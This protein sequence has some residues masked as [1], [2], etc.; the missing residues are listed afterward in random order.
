MA[1]MYML[2]DFVMM[3]YLDPLK[4]MIWSGSEILM[5]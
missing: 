5:M 1:A 3:M 2:L 4:A